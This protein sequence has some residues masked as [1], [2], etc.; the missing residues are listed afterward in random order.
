MAPAPQ[1]VFFHVGIGR[2]GT[3]F[4]QA[5]FFPKL[6]N[7]AY[8]RNPNYRTGSYT[9]VIRASKAERLLISNEFDRDLADELHNIAARLPQARIIMVLRR[10]DQ[11]IASQYRRRVKN[12]YQG[13]FSDFFDVHHDQGDWKQEVLYFYQHIQLI[14]QLFEQPPLVLLYDELKTDPF[15]FLDKIA[16][17]AG[18]SYARSAINTATKHASYE[19][20]QLNFLHWLNT[21]LPGK[22]QVRLSP[23]LKWRKVQQQLI[24]AP[25]F[26]L[27]KLAALAP[28]GWVPS[29]PL[30][31][32]A[33]LEAIRQ[34][35]QHDWEQCLT[36]IRANNAEVSAKAGSSAS[37]TGN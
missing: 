32:E 18:A 22:A 25:R 5:R 33:E 14:E 34:F 6:R 9:A 3:S 12:G 4:L 27:M 16:A 31:A 29:Q 21:R 17:Y 19:E 7:I 13:R 30:I 23:N 28:E 15:A 26:V 24:K 1:T 8:I 37:L 2:T 10:P 35:Y 36:Y 20:R 11:W